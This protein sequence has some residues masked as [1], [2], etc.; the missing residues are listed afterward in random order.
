MLIDDL[1][2]IARELLIRDGEHQPMFFLCSDEQIIGQPLPT[3][4]FNKLYGNMNAEDFK[5]QAVFCMGIIA[6]KLMANRLIMIWDAA[7]RMAVPGTKREDIAVTD[8][9]L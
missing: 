2:Q 8:M 9:P 7:M 1:K 3:G 5:T 6:K 4:M